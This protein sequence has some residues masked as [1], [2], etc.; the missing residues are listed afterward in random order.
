MGF[1]PLFFVVAERSYLHK[2]LQV[3]ESNFHLSSLAVG[4]D[5][6]SG[7]GFFGQICLDAVTAVGDFH[8]V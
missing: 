1:D 7:V 3:G 4:R 6:K 2:A 5:Q 8:Q